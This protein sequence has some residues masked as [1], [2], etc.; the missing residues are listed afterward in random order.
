LG[1]K[2][3]EKGGGG[4][5]E[6]SWGKRNKKPLLIIRDRIPGPFQKKGP[7]SS[8]RENLDLRKGGGKPAWKADDTEGTGF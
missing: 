3:G 4:E 8:G 5:K 6:L 2:E 7:P 1:K